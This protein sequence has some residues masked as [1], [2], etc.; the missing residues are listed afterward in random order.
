MTPSARDSRARA[1]RPRTPRQFR[2]PLLALGRLNT[3]L[4]SSR[5]GQR[6]LPF[7]APRLRRAARSAA[8]GTIGRRSRGDG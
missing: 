2:L 1:G 7:P 3:W 8:A 5:R 6:S 4:I